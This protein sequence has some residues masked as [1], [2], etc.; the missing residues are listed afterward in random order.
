MYIDVMSFVIGMIA[1]ELISVYV[2]SWC[3][4]LKRNVRKKAYEKEIK[5]QR[6][7]SDYSE[8]NIGFTAKL[9]EEGTR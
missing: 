5:K 6:E 7:T 9:K 4:T 3:R 8:T 2:N 1:C